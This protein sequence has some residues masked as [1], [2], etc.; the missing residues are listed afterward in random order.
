MHFAVGN[1]DKRGDIA[2]QVQ[3]RMHLHR[4]FV[5][6]KLGPGKQRKAKIDGGRIQSVQTL[7][8]IHAD[9]IVGIQRPC[10][11]D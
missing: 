5:L 1:A 4:G 10:D 2:M 6:A 3:Q 11:R 7:I 8:Q 9:G